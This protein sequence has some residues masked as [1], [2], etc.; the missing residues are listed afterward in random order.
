MFAALHGQEATLNVH[1]IAK[2]Q[3][4]GLADGSVGV[5]CSNRVETMNILPVTEALLQRRDMFHRNTTGAL[6]PAYVAAGRLLGCFEGHMNARGCLAGQLLIEEAGGGVETQ[7][8]DDSI[9][10]GRRV[11]AGCADVFDDLLSIA[12]AAWS[13]HP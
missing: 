9:A 2:A 13:G 10:Y 11:V 12:D 8:A 7:D 6:S 1:P 3:G 5:G 4:V